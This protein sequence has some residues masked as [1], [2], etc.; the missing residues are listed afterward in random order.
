[1][2]LQASPFLS[3][4]SGQSSIVLAMGWIEGTLLGSIATAIAVVCVATVG[5]MMFSGRIDVRRGLTVAL[6]CFVLFG[7][8]AVVQGFRATR[9]Y[10]R[11]EV[12]PVPP[13]PT[14]SPASS[15]SPE[16]S[17]PYAGASVIRR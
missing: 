6:G 1:M 11:I 12:L 5:L 8:S 2:I 4:P 17:D 9:E 3:D 10:R 14:P 16:L 7:A 15:P 13:L